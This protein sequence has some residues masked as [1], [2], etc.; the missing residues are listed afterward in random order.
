MK[1]YKNGR[2]QYSGDDIAAAFNRPLPS[3]PCTGCPH[4]RGAHRREIVKPGAFDG[5]EAHYECGKRDR[6]TTTGKCKCTQ[7][8]EAP[9][10]LTV[11]A[12]P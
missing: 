4:T 9:A 7:F 8:V 5:V 2:V 12:Q 3:T 6:R 1:Q 11:T 10:P